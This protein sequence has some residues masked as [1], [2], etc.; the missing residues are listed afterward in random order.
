MS[1]AAPSTLPTVVTTAD[2][3]PLKTSLARA[4]RRNKLRALGLVAPLFLFLI[5]TFVFPIGNML[6]RSVENKVVSEVLHRTT[7]LLA[8]WDAT[9]GELP[10]EAVFAALVADVRE[11]REARTIGKV[12]VRLNYEMS[13]MSSLFRKTARRAK[14]VNE[15]PYQAALIKIDK[16]WG[17]TDTW[18]IMQR[19]SRRLT[20]S[21]YLAALDMHLSTSGKIERQSEE[22]QIYVQLFGRTYASV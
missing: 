14:R 5:I 2:G 15:G 4:M 16:K 19:E 6:F 20:N 8:S 21:Y 17:V 7:P 9:S 10:N 1:S 12:G 18:R 3:A 22:R 13:G 11:G